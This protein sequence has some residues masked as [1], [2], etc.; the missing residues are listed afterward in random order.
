MPYGV[1]K[2]IGGDSKENVSWVEKCVSSIS[3]KNKRTGKP[4]TEGEKIAICK[5]QLSKNK[6]KNAALEG[7]IKIDE[8]ILEK[9][10]TTASILV[11]KVVEN[12]RVSGELQAEE[13]FA[14][15]LIKS[16]YDLDLLSIVV[17]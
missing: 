8:D 17:F 3:G 13:L 12:K 11:K 7:E 2:K 10:D 1:D 9:L 14:N 6:E 5:A 15:L 16:N 4:Y